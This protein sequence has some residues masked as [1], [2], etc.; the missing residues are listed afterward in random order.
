M[1][2]SR[3]FYTSYKSNELFAFS[4][5]NLY[6]HTSEQILKLIIF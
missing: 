2:K 6:Y 5:Y 3:I 4:I 1:L